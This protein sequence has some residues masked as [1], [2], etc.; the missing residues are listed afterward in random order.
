[1]VVL[2]TLFLN[3]FV[4]TISEAMRQELLMYT[5]HFQYNKEIC[6][7]VSQLSAPHTDIIVQK[8]V[9]RTM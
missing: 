8:T 6:K 5:F 9:I 3:F 1:M 2:L 7:Y 4:L